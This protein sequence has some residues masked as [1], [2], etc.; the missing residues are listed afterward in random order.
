MNLQTTEKYVCQA[1]IVRALEKMTP[2]QRDLY[3]N[4]RAD[5]GIVLEQGG[6]DEPSTKGPRL[7]LAGLGLAQAAGFSLYTSSA[8]ALAFLSGSVGLTLPF[9]AYTGL[10]SLLSLVT[11]PLGWV[12]MGSLIAWKLTSTDWKKLAPDSCM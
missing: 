7:G 10:S 1:I 8:S 12:A 3:F 11:G 4:E 5:F 2:A 9:A 6:P